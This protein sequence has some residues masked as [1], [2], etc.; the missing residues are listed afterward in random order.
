[1]LFK[2]ALQ[3]LELYVSLRVLSIATTVIACIAVWVFPIWLLVDFG[4]VG[5]CL[6]VLA[7]PVILIWALAVFLG[8]LGQYRR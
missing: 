8:A 1:M 2:D 6:L 5:I 7:I 3:L 4:I